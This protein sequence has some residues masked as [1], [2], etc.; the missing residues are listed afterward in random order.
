MDVIWVYFFR[1]DLPSDLMYK[2]SPLQCNTIITM[3][4]NSWDCTEEVSKIGVSEAHV[5][6][7]AELGADCI[8]ADAHVRVG[9]QSKSVKNHNMAYNSD[10]G[11]QLANMHARTG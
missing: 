7:F 10:D 4:N 1:D 3:V 11:S 8:I 6:K 9:F 5:P 2:G